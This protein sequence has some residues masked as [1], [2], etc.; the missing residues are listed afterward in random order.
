MCTSRDHLSPVWPSPQ[1]LIPS[2]LVL[3]LRSLN[4]EMFS[5]VCWS[6]SMYLESVALLPQLYM[7]QKQA[8]DEGGIVEVPL[9]LDLFSQ[10]LTLTSFI[11]SHESH[12]VC[13]GLLSC[14]RIRFLD[15]LLC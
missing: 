5:D 8:T 4:N 10:L 13:L 11:E 9:I 7:F 6:A 2:S 3:L 1:T 14:V 15:D 12:G